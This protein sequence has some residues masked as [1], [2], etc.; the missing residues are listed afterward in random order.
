MKTPGIRLRGPPVQRMNFI[1]KKLS[2]K[3]FIKNLKSNLFK[4]LYWG[5]R[6]RPQ[7]S[8]V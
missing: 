8:G 1:Q 2:T 5:E 4:L 6:R 3:T 7:T